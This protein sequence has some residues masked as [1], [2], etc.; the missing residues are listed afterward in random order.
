MNI[1]NRRL[2]LG[3]IRRRESRASALV[4]LYALVAW[5]VYVTLWY[6]GAL[7]VNLGGKAGR[8]GGVIG[9]PILCVLSSLHWPNYLRVTGSC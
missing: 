7:P 3:E 6:V 2:R 1:E 9:G 8:A 5:V 4:T